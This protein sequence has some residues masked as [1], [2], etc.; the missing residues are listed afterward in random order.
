MLY[1]GPERSGPF[2]NPPATWGT[3]STTFPGSGLSDL[4][5]QHLKKI[6]FLSVHVVAIGGGAGE[7]MVDEVVLEK[8][9][10]TGSPVR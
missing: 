6:C 2:S 1:F 3:G 4:A 5:R 8:F 9:P 10:R 7:W